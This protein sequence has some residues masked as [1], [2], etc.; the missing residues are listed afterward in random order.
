MIWDT[1]DR[2]F[3]GFECSSVQ[4]INEGCEYNEKRVLLPMK[5]LMIEMTIIYKRAPQWQRMD[6]INNVAESEINVLS[7]THRHG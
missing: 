6:R 2:R 5:W 7:L 1:S 4:V 3:E